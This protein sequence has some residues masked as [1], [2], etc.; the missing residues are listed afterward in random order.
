MGAAPEQVAGELR[1]REQSVGGDQA[2]GDV[3][4]V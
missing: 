1:L 3:E 2:A 4:R